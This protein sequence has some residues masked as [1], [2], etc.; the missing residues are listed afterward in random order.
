MSYSARRGF[1]NGSMRQTGA[2]RQAEMQQQ[3]LPVM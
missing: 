2:Q 1:S 3:G